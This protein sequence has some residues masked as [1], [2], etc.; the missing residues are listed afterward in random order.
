[1]D[2]GSSVELPAKTFAVEIHFDEAEMDKHLAKKLGL[3]WS[4]GLQSAFVYSQ[5][6]TETRWSQHQ[7]FQIPESATGVRIVLRKWSW[8]GEVEEPCVKLRL[9]SKTVA[10]EFSL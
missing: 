2:L 5:P 4:D 6:V 10:T 9:C 1:M 8:N 7:D 3:S